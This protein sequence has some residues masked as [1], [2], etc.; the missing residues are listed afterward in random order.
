MFSTRRHGKARAMERRG[1]GFGF[2]AK[3][4]EQPEL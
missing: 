2:A 1:D 3:V 4:A